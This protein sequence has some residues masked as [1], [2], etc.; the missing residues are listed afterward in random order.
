MTKLTPRSNFVKV[1][2]AGLRTITNSRSPLFHI[3]RPTRPVD[4][5]Y[6]KKVEVEEETVAKKKDLTPG[7]ELDKRRALIAGELLATEESYVNELKKLNVCSQVFFFFFGGFDYA[8]F[9]SI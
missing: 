8:P 4:Y 5:T 9:H 6:N 2:N 1:P 7:P 3:E